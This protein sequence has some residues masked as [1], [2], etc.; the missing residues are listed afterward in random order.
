MNRF[1]HVRNLLVLLAVMLMIPASSYALVDGSIYGGYAFGGKLEGT[2]ETADVS[3]YHYGARVHANLGIPMVVSF[4]LGMFYEIA[5]MKYEVNGKEDDLKKETLGI[6]V[7]AQLKLPVIPINPFIRYGIAINDKVEVT[8]QDQDAGGSATETF[9][10]NFKSSYYGIGIA[11]SLLDAIVMDIQLFGEYLYT[12][13]KQEKG[14]E[15]KGNV[16]NLGV[17]VVL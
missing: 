17:Q 13:S 5:P 7:Y 11:Y 8:Y 6:D 4:G 12:T 15:L 1:T 9:Q 3:G 10:E 2:G 16:V 14:I